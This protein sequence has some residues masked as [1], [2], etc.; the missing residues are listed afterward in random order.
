MAEKKAVA[1]I[2][3]A[4][5]PKVTA[6]VLNIAA[7][8]E[9]KQSVPSKLR[10]VIFG[11]K[12]NAA[13]PAIQGEF[14]LDNVRPIRNDLSDADLEVVSSVVKVGKGNL[15]TTTGEK[16]QSTASGRRA[17]KSDS[18]ISSAAAVPQTEPTPE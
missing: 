10:A 3:P 15:Q 4:S 2:A 13:Q 14:A 18:A 7:K 8:P 12:R 6:P 9:I 16:A 5:A 11:R 1:P 17:P